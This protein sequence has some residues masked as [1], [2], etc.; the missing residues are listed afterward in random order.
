[1]RVTDGDTVTLE[2]TRDGSGASITSDRASF[3]VRTLPAQDFPRLPALDPEQTAT[4]DAGVIAA[5]VERVAKAASR[6]ETR[7]VLTGILVSIEDQTL[8]MV[9]TDSYRLSVKETAGGRLGRHVRRPTCP[10]ARSRS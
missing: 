9:A 6:D 10:P 2:A 3:N 7:P 1:M 4:L 5:T 8:R